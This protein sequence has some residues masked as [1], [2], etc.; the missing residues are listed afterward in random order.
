MR[1]QAGYAE[2]TFYD[3]S[4]RTGH[5]RRRRLRE[6]LGLDAE[7]VE[8]VMRLRSQLVVIQRLV[9]ELQAELAVHRSGRHLRL[10]QHLLNSAEAS[11]RD[12]VYEDEA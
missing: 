2:Y 7:S 11:W 8:I 12:V 1:R 6:D 9:L 3:D 5:R 4:D 10:T